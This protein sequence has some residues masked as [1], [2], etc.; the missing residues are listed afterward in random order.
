MPFADLLL[1]LQLCRAHI[2]V[3]KKTY[4]HKINE[5]KMAKI[6]P[7]REIIFSIHDVGNLLGQ[8][9]PQESQICILF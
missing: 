5:S 4:T 1:Y 3:G 8:T 2:H 6:I 7:F 9:A